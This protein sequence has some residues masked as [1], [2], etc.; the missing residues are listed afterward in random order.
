MYFWLA[1]GFLAL[2]CRFASADDPVANLTSSSFGQDAYT[3]MLQRLSVAD[4]WK[5]Y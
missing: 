1:W 4:D 5:I 3:L 2:N